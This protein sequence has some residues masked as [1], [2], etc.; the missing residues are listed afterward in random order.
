MSLADI[1][2]TIIND[3]NLLRKNALAS[4]HH[5]LGFDKIIL[6]SNPEYQLHLHIWWPDKIR[7]IEG[8]HN[9]KFNF[10]SKILIGTIVNNIYDRSNDDT[11][12]NLHEYISNPVSTKEFDDFEYLG[13]T[14]LVKICSTEY[15]TGNIYVMNHNDFHTIDVHPSNKLTAT[16]F[17]RSGIIKDR[18]II[19]EINPFTSIPKNE[20]IKNDNIDENEYINILN[21]FLDEMNRHN[22]D[23]TSV[24]EYHNL[25]NIFLDEMSRHNINITIP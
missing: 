4:Q 17:L 21:I 8:I 18:D 24:S 16:L 20:I 15:S 25:S 3:S 9:H 23:I 11:G 14:N 19:F 22:I 12:L 10:V 6:I 2:S 7:R 5:R 1:I 13:I